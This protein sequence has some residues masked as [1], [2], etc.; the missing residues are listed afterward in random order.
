MFWTYISTTKINTEEDTQT[1]NKHRAD[2]FVFR[3]IMN[4]LTAFL[5]VLT[6]S[7]ILSGNSLDFWEFSKRVS[8]FFLF[9]GMYMFACEIRPPARETEL[10][11]VFHD[12]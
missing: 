5:F 4:F 10:K 7:S 3:S 2:Y 11:P 6:V 8:D 1:A 9:I 12:I